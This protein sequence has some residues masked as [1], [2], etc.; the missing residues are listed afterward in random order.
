MPDLHIRGWND[1]RLVLGQNLKPEGEKGFEGLLAR[2]FSAQIGQPFYLARTGDQPAGDVYS[3][4]A[5]IAL[6]AKRYTIAKIDQ[7]NVEGDID[8]ALRETPNTD[9][10]IVATTRV[11]NQLKLRLEKK[12]EETGVDIILLALGDSISPLGALIVNHW[13]ILREFLLH[14]DEYSDEWA[15]TQRHSP[16]LQI[17]LGHFRSELSGLPSRIFTNERARGALQMR[18]KDGDLNFQTLNRIDISDGIPR[19]ICHKALIDWWNDPRLGIAVLE[20]EE[21]TGKS[22]IAA[23]FADH[24]PGETP[25]AIWLDSLAWCQAKKI[26]EIVRAGLELLF[27]PG[28]KRPARVLQKVFRRWSEPLLIV[29][30]GANE[31]GAWAAAEKLLYNYHQ[32]SENLRTRVRLVFTSRPLDHQPKA[33]PH[34]WGAARIIPVGPFNEA[35][36]ATAM[37]KFSP[38]VRP[39]T[40]TAAVHDLAKVPRYFRLCLQLREKL[41]SFTHINRQILLWADLEAKLERRDPQWLGIQAE[42]GASPKEILAHL[43]QHIGWPTKDTKSIGTAELKQFLPDFQKVHADLREQR[44]VLSAGLTETMLSAEHLVLGWALVLQGVAERNSGKNADSLCEQLQQLLEPAASNENKARAVHVATLLTFFSSNSTARSARAALLR[45]WVVHHNANVTTEALDFFVSNDLEAYLHVVEALFRRHLPGDF[46]STLISPV[47]THWRDGNNT[48][49]LGRTLERWLRLI[50]PGDAS[51]SEFG[52][53]TPPPQFVAAETP[54][55]MRLSY[56]AIGIISFR[57]ELSLLPALVDCYRSDDYCFAEQG[58]EKMPIR[59]PIKTPIEPLGLLVRWHFGEPGL[60]VLSQLAK[61]TSHGGDDW[62]HIHG[63][64]RLWRM[65][66]IPA[67]LGDGEGIASARDPQDDL[68]LYCAFRDSIDES[69]SLERKFLGLDLIGRLAIRPDFPEL[70]PKEIN[71]ILEITEMLL[72]SVDHT[73]LPGS[74]EERCFRDLLP[75]LARYSTETM[76]KAVRILWQYAIGAPES[77]QRLYGLN[78]LMPGND[79]GGKLTTA[80][81]THSQS[82]LRQENAEI[83][84]EQVTELMLFHSDPNNL[85]AWLRKIAGL[86]IS[87]SNG[88]AIGTNSLAVAF[89]ELA[90]SHFESVAL[91]EAE[92]ALREF[93]KAPST[94]QKTKV[95]H[96]TQILAYVVEKPSLELCHWALSLA[97]QYHDHKN[98]HF[99]LFL[100]LSRCKDATILEQTLRHPSF[101][102]F[103]TG[104][105][106]WRWSFAFPKAKWPTFTWDNLKDYASLTAGGWILFHSGQD[107]ELCKWGRSF[108]TSALDALSG[109]PI[110]PPETNIEMRVGDG[111]HLEGTFI[112]NI[113]SGHESWLGIGS[114]AW[115]VDRHSVRLSPS[116]ADLDRRCDA[117]HAHMEERRSS[118]RRE[119]VNFNAAGP[120]ERWSRIAPKEFSLWAEEFLA[121]ASNADFQTRFEMA[122]LIETIAISLFRLNPENPSSAKLLP[123]SPIRITSIGGKVL[124]REEVIWELELNHSNVVLKARRS[125]LFDA[126][127][128]E[129]LMWQVIAAHSKKNATAI[130]KFVEDWIESDFARERVLAVTLMAFQADENALPKL[131]EIQNNDPSFWVRD[132]ARWASDIC[133]NEIA[134]QRRYTEILVETSFESIVAGLAEI[135]PALTPLAFAWWKIDKNRSLLAQQA[136]RNRALIQLFWARWSRQSTSRENIKLSGRKLREYCRGERLQDG[137]SSRMAPWWQIE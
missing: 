115:G 104:F 24:L 22:W 99:P 121:C 45:L 98:L 66:E 68:S 6:Q 23:N 8:R 4:Q 31:R 117:L 87:M 76:H 37:A 120:L 16:D 80:A 13:H 26:E 100:I 86:T 101:A 83:V 10:F 18:F 47:A 82:L 74:H 58:T 85:L 97:D 113:P 64:S 36:F 103:Q 67:E 46:E 28:D 119:F 70:S 126:R 107:D 42:L 73:T 51:G 133:A 44:I 90:P 29:L 128:D 95:C 111:S 5:G 15:G 79:P 129:T 61:N 57:P 108:S 17:A 21:G 135:R 30:D 102:E 41:A 25:V 112:E 71:Q 7:N 12:T 48:A 75:F 96:W 9:I 93:S 116:Q 2:L 52:D 39:E 125:L 40:L 27:P 69:G 91:S 110:T 136:K 50:F 3:P 54:E 62:K 124:H 19:L 53:K 94:G 137:V 106:A 55:Q 35:E 65:A 20:G 130:A 77:W 127:N 1:L 32:H 122:Y 56:T 34:F 131:Q 134:C 89:A 114:P 14:I 63:F 105:N 11:D 43:A 118:A 49:L 132:H 92:A 60:L 84:A 78:E 33:G 72:S 81:N 88:P 109:T 38:G 59:L 123:A